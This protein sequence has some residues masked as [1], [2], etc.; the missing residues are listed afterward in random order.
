MRR[1]DDGYGRRHFRRQSWPRF[2]R[3]LNET[4]PSI[5]ED[6]GRTSGLLARS[7]TKPKNNENMR[8][9]RFSASR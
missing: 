3:D 9:E 7:Q 6:N 4:L 5:P 8:A 2:S 1:S